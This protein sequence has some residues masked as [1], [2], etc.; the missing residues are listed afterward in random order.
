MPNGDGGGGGGGGYVPS[1]PTAPG[2]A[3]PTLPPVGGLGDPLPT[4]PPATLQPGG[5]IITT[6]NTGGGMI[7]TG[8]G[9]HPA[10]L[11]VDYGPP[12]GAG[13]GMLEWILSAVLAA[14]LVSRR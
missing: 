6:T 11:E 5:T 13:D 9:G 12:A 7:P 14:A 4:L 3:I 2:D 8:P 10:P 1:G